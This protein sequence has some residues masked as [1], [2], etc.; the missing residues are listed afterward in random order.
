[1]VNAQFA[2]FDWFCDFTENY[3]WGIASG[4]FS[5]FVTPLMYAR[6]SY[7]KNQSMRGI[8][9]IFLSVGIM[10]LHIIGANMIHLAHIPV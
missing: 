8:W 1:M 10:S 6:I 3:L 4:M 5:I 2:K 7:K 9:T